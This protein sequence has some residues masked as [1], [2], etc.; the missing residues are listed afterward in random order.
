MTRQFTS[1]VLVLALALAFGPTAMAQSSGKVEKQLSPASRAFER[2]KSIE[3]EW[4]GRSTK[5]WVDTNTFQVIAAGSVLMGRSFDSHANETMVTM[6]HL[7]GDELMLTHYCVARNQPRLRAT[8]ISPDGR[9]IELTFRDS[10]NL[11][12]RDR[13][14]MDRVVMTFVDDD[15]FT[16]Q[17]TWY[18][19]GKEKWM[20][21]IEYVRRKAG[22]VGRPDAA[23]EC[24][25]Q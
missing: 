13:G 25:R 9:T 3:G 7:D 18:Q 22:A 14:H 2:L 19:D 8:T 20:E 24:H 23:S 4:D 6:Y 10:T 16:S 17:W 5:G 12:S 15:H 11:P 1:F 21:K